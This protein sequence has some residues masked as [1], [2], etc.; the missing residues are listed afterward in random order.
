LETNKLKKVGISLLS[1]LIS[2]YISFE[3]YN[4][5]FHPLGKL[6]GNIKIDQSCNETIKDIKEYIK[7]DKGIFQAAYRKIN[8]LYRD[9]ESGE[10]VKESIGYFINQGPRFIGISLKIR[11]SLEGKVKQVVYD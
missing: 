6:S 10:G 1:L 5:Y 2:I 8:P 11:C 3:V 4:T 7:N 9:L